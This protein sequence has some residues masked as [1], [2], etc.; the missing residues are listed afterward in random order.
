MILA[1]E[2]T[3]IFEVLIFNKEHISVFNMYSN[4]NA[5]PAPFYHLPTV[6]ETSCYPT[7]WFDHKTIIEF[8]IICDIED[9]IA[10]R[11]QDHLESLFEDDG[12]QQIVFALQANEWAILVV[13]GVM[14]TEALEEFVGEL[15]L[16]IGEVIAVLVTKELLAKVIVFDGPGGEKIFPWYE[17]YFM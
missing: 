3:C 8:T 17:N 1:S 10:K 2:T 12:E 14:N 13:N 16:F 4:Q 9:D 6:L 15:E 11:F 7:I 5:L